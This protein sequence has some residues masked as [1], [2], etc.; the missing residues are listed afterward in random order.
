VNSWEPEEN[1]SGC[2]D[3]VDEFLWSRKLTSKSNENSKII[4]IS[5]ANDLNNCSDTDMD[6]IR[7]AK[8]ANIQLSSQEMIFL[9]IF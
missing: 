6:T 3:L 5:S 8:R 7:E 2:Q 4:D 1:L 9:S